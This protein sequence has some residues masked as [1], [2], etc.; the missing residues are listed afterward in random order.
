MDMEA[1]SLAQE[2]AWTGMMLS[3]KDPTEGALFYHATYVKPDWSQSMI[4]TTKIGKHLYFIDPD[5]AK[6]SQALHVASSAPE[7]DTRDLLS[8]LY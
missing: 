5:M 3:P 7:P 4:R 8:Q 2:I 1:W 6:E